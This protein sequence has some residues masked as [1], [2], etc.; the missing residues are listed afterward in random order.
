MVGHLQRWP[1][2]IFHS[3]YLYAALT[4]KRYKIHYPPCDLVGMSGN[5]TL[6]LLSPGFKRSGSFHFLL[7][8]SQTTGEE[9]SLSS[10]MLGGS[11]RDQL[12]EVMWREMSSQTPN[13]FS[14][15]SWSLDICFKSLYFG[16]SERSL[17]IYDAKCNFG[18]HVEKMEKN[19]FLQWQIS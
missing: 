8:G 17:S 11:S 3:L 1:P 4:I 6:G 19:F 10:A 5:D 13:C 18:A 14:H 7:P 15:L 2:P 12:G 9:V 16:I